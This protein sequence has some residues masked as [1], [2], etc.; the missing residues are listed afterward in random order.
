MNMLLKFDR[1]RSRI[2]LIALTFMLAMSV[3]THSSRADGSYR[4]DY[5][6]IEVGLVE[7]C[8][9]K[10]LICST[11]TVMDDSRL[12]PDG[13][14]IGETLSF[15]Y[16]DCSTRELVCVDMIEF[17]LAIPKSGNNSEKWSSG[18]W[19]FRR[20]ACLSGT[21]QN[22]A[23]MA[24]AFRNDKERREGGFV[25]DNK[26]GVELYYYSNVGRRDQR[27]VYALSSEFG[28]LQGGKP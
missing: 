5:V 1:G 8:D 14:I 22:C 18:D 15:G 23:R 11:T 10:V 13:R 6:N 19:H 17:M 20:T 4:A 27:H 12:T 9:R 25:I 24:V 26:R 3:C 21:V 16:G 7:S 2:G 28:L